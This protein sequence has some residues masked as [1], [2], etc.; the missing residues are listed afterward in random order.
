M[1]AFLGGGCHGLAA[2]TTDCAKAINRDVFTVCGRGGTCS[3]RNG[4]CFAFGDCNSFCSGFLT[5]LGCTINGCSY[6]GSPVGRCYALAD[7]RCGYFSDCYSI[8][9]SH[10]NA[11]DCRADLCKWDSNPEV[12]TTC[13]LTSDNQGADAYFSAVTAESTTKATLAAQY[14]LLTAAACPVA[15]S[16]NGRPSC[17]FPSCTPAVV[18]YACTGDA[19]PSSLTPRQVS[20]RI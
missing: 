20:I 19:P 4:D 6:S 9:A 8:C 14:P 5:N 11:F 2:I 16:C 10:D 13:D 3:P 15:A 18:Q 12:C 7:W 1:C 17:S